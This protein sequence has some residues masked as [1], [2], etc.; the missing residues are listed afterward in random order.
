MQE[1]RMNWIK[2]NWR[3]AAL[4]L[5]AAGALIITLSRGSDE[6]SAMHTFDP[7]LEGGKWAIRFLLFS[8][9]M[10]PL[11]TYVGWSWAIKLRKPAGLWAFGFAGVHVAFYI[12]DA[13]LNWLSL[14][15]P[16]YLALGAFGLIVLAALAI[17]SNRWAMR[18][19]KHNW[20]RLHRLVYLASISVCVHA[21]IATTMSKKMFIRDPE[22][23][24]ELRLYLAVLAV[25]LLVRL[26][27]VRRIVK[28]VTAT[29]QRRREVEM[30]ETAVVGPRAVPSVWPTTPLALAPDTIDV[31]VTDP[32]TS[33]QQELVVDQRG[34]G[35][36]GKSDGDG[37]G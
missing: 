37:N 10:T 4:N 27:V 20:K 8:L 23:V 24:Y 33:G 11:A 28:A 14:D 17:T 30:S 29:L 31:Q 26:P 25:L 36:V 3:W 1:G 35:L 18:R 13:K 6:W 21:I 19:L 7:G 34:I 15:M 9:L 22:A 32:H 5:F 12:R 16:L 2:A